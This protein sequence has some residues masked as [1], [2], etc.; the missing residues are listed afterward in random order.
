MKAATRTRMVLI[1]MHK[2]MNMA[3]PQC[4]RAL[5]A[6]AQPQAQARMLKATTATLLCG[7]R[8]FL[9]AARF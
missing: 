4:Q 5:Q 8:N 7:I 3:Q 1:T 9:G 6:Q 2:T